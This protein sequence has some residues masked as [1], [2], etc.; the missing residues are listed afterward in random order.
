MLKKTIELERAVI[1]MTDV[2][3]AARFLGEPVSVEGEAVDR[4]RS[5]AIVREDLTIHL[6][7]LPEWPADVLGKTVSATGDLTQTGEDEGSLFVIHDF[8][9][10]VAADEDESA[11]ED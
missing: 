7:D 3:R 11:D 6:L 1:P 2:G 8:R 4:E 5:A 9:Y 10:E